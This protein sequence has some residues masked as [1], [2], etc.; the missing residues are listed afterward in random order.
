MDQIRIDPSDWEGMLRIMDEHGDSK[1]MFP[2]L[3][4]HGEMVL[5]S[6]FKDRII[7]NTCQKNGWMRKNIYH[8]DGT[9]EELYERGEPSD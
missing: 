7:T 6:V 9:T 5:I 4:E 3:S 8:R 1:T 2:G